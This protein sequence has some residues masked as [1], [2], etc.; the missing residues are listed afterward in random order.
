MPAVRCPLIDYDVVENSPAA[1]QTRIYNFLAA[2]VRAWARFRRGA[3][4]GKQVVLWVLRACDEDVDSEKL[5][6]SLAF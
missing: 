6:Y 3:K 1:A 5:A 4:L 2:A